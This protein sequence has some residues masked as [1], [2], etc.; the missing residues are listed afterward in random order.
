MVEE[1]V[2]FESTQDEVR[3][4]GEPVGRCRTPVVVSLLAEDEL[5]TAEEKAPKRQ[6]LMKESNC[7]V[8]DVHLMSQVYVLKALLHRYDLQ[9]DCVRA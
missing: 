1:A 2:V 6:K 4:D 8:K 7:D 5:D 3:I 9:V